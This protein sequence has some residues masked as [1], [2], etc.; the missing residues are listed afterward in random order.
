VENLNQMR[1][2]FDVPA[3]TL[4][5]VLEAFPEISPL[6]L[7]DWVYGQPGLRKERM[8]RAW[9]E[10]VLSEHGRIGNQARNRKLSP[11]ER[12]SLARHA[13]L[14]KHHKNLRLTSEEVTLHSNGAVNG[15]RAGY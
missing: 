1:E 10:I 9:R 8:A 14:C 2:A 5:Q 15:A 3:V 11:N 13:A 6:N 7:L 12:S 4:D